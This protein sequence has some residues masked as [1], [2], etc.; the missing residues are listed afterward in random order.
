M[1]TES[2]RTP[3]ARCGASILLATAKRNNSLCEPCAIRHR[4]ALRETDALSNAA[5][6]RIPLAK[7]GMTAADF[8]KGL[9]RL[10]DPL[11]GDAKAAS[12]KFLEYCEPI[13]NQLM[14]SAIFGGGKSLMYKKIKGI[15]RPFRELIAAYQ[16]WGMIMSDGFECYACDTCERF[17]EEVDI[18]LIAMSCKQAVGLMSASRKSYERNGEHLPKDVDEKIWVHFHDEMPNFESKIIGPELLT[19]I[20]RVAK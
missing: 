9:A 4:D 17:D 3:C 6:N 14:L 15:P 10:T 5:G 2:N 13:F 19:A 11:R 7:P 1:T 16:A 20:A 18:G 8:A 12:L